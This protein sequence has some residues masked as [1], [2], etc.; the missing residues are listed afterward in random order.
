MAA[1]FPS[2]KPTTRSFTMG[3]YPSRTYTSLSGAVF[4]RSFGNRATGYTL[5]LT[6]KNI[7]DTFEVTEGCGTVKQI[8]DHFRTVTN[9]TFKSFSLPEKVFAGLYSDEPN[10]T[11]RVN[12][13][14][15]PT[16]KQPDSITWRYAEPPKVQ[17]V[18]SGLSTVTVKLIGE[19]KAV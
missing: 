19:I 14:L 7:G 9:G 16:I 8:V 5:D 13:N 12:N 6:F 11:E 1:T 18:R 3:D 17:S 15:N 2:M 4:K 10:N